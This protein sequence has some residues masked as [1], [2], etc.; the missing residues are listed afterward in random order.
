LTA[1]TAFFRIFQDLSQESTAIAWKLQ[2]CKKTFAI[3]SENLQ[4]I[5]H[6]LIF[7]PYF[8]FWYLADILYKLFEDLH[9]EKKT[10]ALYNVAR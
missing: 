6:I 5:S 2:K 8:V 4:N 10:N 3:N 9:P 1:K 7:W